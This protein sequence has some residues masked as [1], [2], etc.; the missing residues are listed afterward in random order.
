M[1]RERET[2]I[3]RVI[4][5][6]DG[7]LVLLAYILSYLLRQNL[8]KFH[9][10]SLLSPLRI[11]HEKGGTFSDH[12]VIIFFIVPFWCLVLYLN[13][14]YQPLRTKP[15]AKIIW[16][17]I[18]SALF[19]NLG[20]GMLV[21]LFKLS[22]MSRIFFVLF[23]ILSFVFILAE[24]AIIYSVMHSVRKRG[25]NQQRL[26]IVG[27][28]KRA[29]NFIRKIKNHPEWG[30]MIIG[31]I[32]DE[33]SL[34]IERVDGVK[35]IGSLKNLTKILHSYAIDEV[36]FVVPRLRLHYMEDAIHKC[37]IEGVRVTISVDLFDLK[38]AKS[39]QTELEGIP[40]LTFKTTLPSESDLFIKRTLDIIISGIVLLIFSP[41]FLIISAL[42]KLTSRGPVLY[43]QERIGMNGRRFTM[44]KFRT[45]KLGADE[46]LSNVDVYEE[47]YEPQWK[48][49]KINYITPIGRIFRKFSL[50]ELPQLFN[51]F[52]GHMSL[53]GPRPMTPEQVQQYKNWHRRRFSMRPG[54]TCLWQ[55]N[56]RRNIK[57]KEWMEMDLEYLDDW[58]LWLDIKILVK[59]IP[60]VLFG[61]GAY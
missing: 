13:G 54:L 43:K 55:V 29:A 35:V 40:L 23:S 50:D 41:L 6:I 49:K 9:I 12:L 18:K 42:I 8:D 47:I 56:G 46:Q 38:I 53:V 27:T 48:E 21:F 34:G 24:K 26:L 37:E 45:M 2:V 59:T 33:P 31:A 25:Y 10:S 28:G 5:I 20:F 16:I 36:I 7:G 30:L 60:A 15:F 4:L 17:L 19:A 61:T 39:Y 51:V 11:M 52:W 32:D 3:R 14:M 1:I 44:Y 22:F 57:F 58:S